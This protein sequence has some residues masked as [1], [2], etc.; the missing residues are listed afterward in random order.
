MALASF[1]SEFSVLR[2]DKDLLR[3]LLL[4][5]RI[6]NVCTV[7]SSSKLFSFSIS[8]ECLDVWSLCLSI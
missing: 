3:I 7:P 8:A 6:L 2:S 4:S 5:S 1:S